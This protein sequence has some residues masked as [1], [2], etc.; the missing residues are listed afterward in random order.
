MIE[1]EIYLTQFYGKNKALPPQILQTTQKKQMLGDIC[2][3][4]LGNPLVLKMTSTIKKTNGLACLQQLNSQV[5]F[6]F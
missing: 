3:P 6:Y 5:Q 4:S 1:L 2:F